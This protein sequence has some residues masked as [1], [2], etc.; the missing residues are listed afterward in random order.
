[1]A[2][3]IPEI[4]FEAITAIVKEKRAA[5]EGLNSKIQW[6]K[7]QARGFRSK[8]R[9]QRAIMFHFGGLELFPSGSNLELLFDN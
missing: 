9:F 3:R 2:E 4:I 6:I 8:E 1:M 5:A 7:Y